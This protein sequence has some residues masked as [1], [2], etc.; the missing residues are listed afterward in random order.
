MAGK[1]E[2][3]ICGTRVSGS[4]CPDCGHTLTAEEK[5][6]Q[7]ASAAQLPKYNFGDGT[8]EELGHLGRIEVRRTSAD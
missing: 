1:I 2:C 5:Q 8:D 7:K 3:P 6:K 4:F